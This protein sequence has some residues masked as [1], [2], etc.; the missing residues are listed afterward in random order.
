[1]KPTADPNH[2][3]LHRNIEFISS[4]KNFY[5]FIEREGLW[6]GAERERILNRFHGHGL[7]LT[8][9]RS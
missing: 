4:L 8:T 5:L 2:L 6:G 1:M 7:D 3:T 9:L